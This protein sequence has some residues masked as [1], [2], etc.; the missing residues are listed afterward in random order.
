MA[1]FSG[2]R[3]CGE[4]TPDVIARITCD[5]V[6]A[7]DVGYNDFFKRLDECYPLYRGPWRSSVT[8]AV[9]A[10]RVYAARYPEAPGLPVWARM[11][12]R[13]AL[14]SQRYA[15]FRSSLDLSPLPEQTAR[16]RFRPFTAPEARAC[17]GEVVMLP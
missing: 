2:E 6:S 7:C 10:L 4:L 16:R 15:R 5:P 9:A 11:R 3:G 8:H 14:A 13:E 12:D 1:H 17:S